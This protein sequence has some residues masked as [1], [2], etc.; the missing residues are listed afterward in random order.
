MHQPHPLEPTC[1]SPLRFPGGKSRA[2]S[3]LLWFL[4][5]EPG[6]LV[7][8]F[9]GGGSLELAL[10][11]RG[12]RVHGFD[13][14]EPLVH[15]WQAALTDPQALT[16]KVEACHPLTREQFCELQRSEPT[17]PLDQAARFFVLNRASF[18]GS[19]LSGGFSPGHPRFTQ[20]SIER[21][22]RFRAPNVWVE[23]ADF[24]QSIPRSIPNH[25]DALLFLD[26]PYCTPRRL[27]GRRGDLHEGFD[28]EALRE[29][30]GQ[31]G[32]WILCYDDCGRVRQM[33][34]GYAIRPLQWAYGMNRTKRS[35]EIVILSPDMADRAGTSQPRHPASVVR[36]APRTVPPARRTDR[37][38]GGVCELG[39][40]AGIPGERRGRRAPVGSRS[41]NH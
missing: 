41:S 40:S 29:L 11:A 13:A 12:W 31:R 6:T 10:A 18:S 17:A 16:D 30:L 32:R 34:G 25:P 5:A 21:L 24:R 4:P 2:V 14:F 33:Y 8:P 22:R 27:Y 38:C 3:Q 15:F 35:N 36:R 37:G 20:S 1:K 7:C 28:H 26:P 23:R 39:R 19:T 9:F